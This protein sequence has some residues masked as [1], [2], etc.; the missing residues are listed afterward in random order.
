MSDALANRMLAD[1]A[2]SLWW[3]PVGEKWIDLAGSRHADVYNMAGF[4]QPL[5]RSRS[6]APM[7]CDGFS[8]RADAATDSV[9]DVTDNWSAEMW[10]QLESKDQ[11]NLLVHGPSHTVN[12]LRIVARTATSPQIDVALHVASTLYR[13]ET[14]SGSIAAG[15][16]YHLVVT[17]DSPT[18]A[19]YLNAAAQT[20]GAS[21][22]NT[23]TMGVLRIGRS[24]NVDGH[25]QGWVGPVA[26]YQGVTLTAQQ[27]SQHYR[28]A[29]AWVDYAYRV[30]DPV[31]AGAMAL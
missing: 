25:A 22:I 29:G 12:G 17:F 23:N 11:Q 24:D 8:T 20:L 19:I 14:P 27:V 5:F 1:G 9:F 7:R 16:I 26:I 31:Q 6:A 28:L 21:T 2:T 15:Q 10:F 18:I 4:G 13:N 3:M 30:T